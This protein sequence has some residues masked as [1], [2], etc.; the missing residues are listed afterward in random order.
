ME[1]PFGDSDDYVD[2]VTTA[3]LRYRN[4]GF[5]PLDSDWDGEEEDD[6]L[7]TMRRTANYY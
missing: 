4:G 2:T 5:I 7:Q 3:L 6:E 1:F